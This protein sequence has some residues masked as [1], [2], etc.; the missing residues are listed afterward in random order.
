MPNVLKIVIVSQQRKKDT[1][2]NNLLT[3]LW[4]TS[5]FSHSARSIGRVIKK[6]M[7]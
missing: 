2:R 6:A 7:Y 4:V 3:N 5:P 1:L